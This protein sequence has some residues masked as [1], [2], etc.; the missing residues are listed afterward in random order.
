MKGFVGIISQWIV[1]FHLH[2]DNMTISYH[3]RQDIIEVMGN[4]SGKLADRFHLLCLEKLGI[5]L[6]F[7]SSLVFAQ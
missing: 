4:A 7:F 2:L 5:Q 6:F 1:F 3:C